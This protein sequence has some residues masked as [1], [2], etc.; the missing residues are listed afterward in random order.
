M[1][2]TVYQPVRLFTGAEPLG[3]AYPPR[4]GTLRLQ[5]CT[6]ARVCKPAARAPRKLPRHP[7]T[8]MPVHH[9][10]PRLRAGLNS[11]D[12]FPT[13]CGMW[14]R[15][16]LAQAGVDAQVVN[17]WLWLSNR[18]AETPEFFPDRER[19]LAFSEELIDAM[20]DGLQKMCAT[21]LSNNI[22]KQL[23]GL[24]LTASP[25]PAAVSHL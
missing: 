1:N 15:W 14:G 19:V 24:A 5:R 21:L 17:C 12:G 9:L 2:Y 8:L 3:S 18:F 11:N 23:K 25:H 6:R 10:L 13:G 20:S 7:P 22:L 16:R 4:L